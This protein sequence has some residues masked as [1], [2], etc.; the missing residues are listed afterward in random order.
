MTKILIFD[1]GGRKERER[2]IKKNKAP[3]DFFQGIDFLRS[4]G[5][6]IKHLSSSIK[7]K[8]NII[9]FFGG[10]LEKI[11]CRISNFGIRPF[12]VNQHKK[13]INNSDIVISLTDG[14]SMSLGFFYTFLD[15]KN[16]IKLV[17]AFH[18]L[19]DYNTKVPKLLKKFYHKLILKILKRLNFIIFYGD[20]D[21]DNSIKKFNLRKEETFLIKFGVDTI[22]WKPN[23]KNNFSSDYLFS[24]GQDPARDFDTLLKVKTNRKIHIHT[25]LLKIRNDNKYV[26]TNGTYHKNKNS[27]TDLEVRQLYQE[28]FAVI[29]PLKN[30]YQ[31]SGYSVTLQAMACGKPV[32]LSNTK[33]LWAPKLFKNRKNCILVNPG[34]EK[35]IEYAI[36]TLENDKKTYEYICNEARKT[37]E[38]HFSLE[39]S[40]LSTLEIFETIVKS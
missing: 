25:S 6:D 7:Y 10:F 22:F 16:K 15:A 1:K 5:F 40:N 14:F 28:S 3:K 11:F 30:V 39:N 29:V 12:S 21:R 8:K 38:K 35:E 33:G 32:I 18:K 26:I 27:L 2:L 13:T 9:Y 20:A 34:S 37:V 4:K 36:Q 19:S 23:N 17:G 31:P 24:I